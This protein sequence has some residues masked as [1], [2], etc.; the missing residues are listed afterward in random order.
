MESAFSLSDW[1]RIFWD[2]WCILQYL[3]E[4]LVEHGKFLI[5]AAL[6]RLLF[7]LP[8]RIAKQEISFA[9]RFLVEI[10]YVAILFAAFSIGKYNSDRIARR[11]E[12]AAKACER[13]M[14]QAQ[15]SDSRF[16]R[17]ELSSEITQV[18]WTLCNHLGFVLP[19]IEQL[20]VEVHQKL[21]NGLIRDVV[22]CPNPEKDR[23]IFPANS[24]VGLSLAE[25]R[26][27]NCPDVKNKQ[28]GDCR[29]FLDP[30]RGKQ[31]GF[32][33][34]LCVP[35]VAGEE[36]VGAVC[37][38]AK[39]EHSLDGK[40]NLLWD[41]AKDELDTLTSFL[42]QLREAEKM[43]CTE[44]IPRRENTTWIAD[45]GAIDA[46]TMLNRNT[47][48]GPSSPPRYGTV[49]L[50]FNSFD[51]GFFGSNLLLQTNAATLRAVY[52]SGSACVGGKRHFELLPSVWF[53]ML[54]REH[55][56]DP[57]R[58]STPPTTDHSI[59]INLA[60]HL[61]LSRLGHEH[62]KNYLARQIVRG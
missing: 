40:N 9:R 44:T 51:D 27:V 26:T 23:E 11:P 45:P 13:A 59:A 37:V 53:I 32:R 3:L 4:L 62:S 35:L 29:T 36:V 1:H 39:T 19:E 34:L 14:Q 48:F 60:T 33:A 20:G 8:L 15:N 5:V 61:L 55:G 7:E 58:V 56:H 52:P 38:S 41:M 10:G 6:A 18:A 47:V 57:R 25:I 49:G 12:S 2:L 31:L 54:R 46:E 24:T 42:K 43:N 22:H 30:P 17:E 21:A 28:G 16:R 50:R